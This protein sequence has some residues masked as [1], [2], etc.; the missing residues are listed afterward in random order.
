MYFSLHLR[1][2]GAAVV[3][4]LT[5]SHA[6]VS[7]APSQCEQVLSRFGDKLIDAA[8]ADSADLTTANLA[9]TPANNAIATLPPFAFTPQA[10]RDT[11]APDP[12]HRTPIAGPVPGVQINARI[13]ED[14]QGQAR[15]LI[16]LPDN[17]NGRLVVAGAP[18]TRSEFNG[19]FA[20]SDY[21]VQKGY[22]YVAQNKGTLNLRATTAADPT[23]CRLNPALGKDTFVHFYDDDPGMP[24]TRW[25]PLMAEA[26]RLGRAA[27][28]IHYGRD[29]QY[30]YAV[31]TSNGGYQVRRA[32]ESYPEL[33][34][35]GVDWEGTFVDADMPNLLSTL[36]P[37]ILNYPAH[38]ASGFDPDSKAAKN[39]RAAGYP[40]DLITTQGDPPTSLWRVHYLQFW[41]VTMCQWQ[42][43]L[44]P[45]YDTYGAGL[46]N[47]VYVNRLS[48]SNVGE[49]LADF[50]TTGRIRR[51]LITVAGTMDALLPIDANARAY[52]RRVAAV[53]REEARKASPAYRLYEVQNGNHIETF[54]VTFPQLEFIQP[55]ALQ[56]FDL[57][58][59]AIENQAELPPSQCIPRGGK[60]AK[61][62]AQPGHCTN[63]MVP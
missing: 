28:Q 60:I 51:P 41:E 27:V 13:A 7:A 55:H 48:L 26:A 57:L 6:L 53:A 56:A 37:A 45:A 32:V 54:K 36:P 43:R 15:V 40:P 21:V 19:D 39:I 8:C 44:D 47:Y 10:D 2:V 52:A 20:W 1:W 12:P 59:S 22:A 29:A 3:A 23:A 24:F 5:I 35:G 17:W 49:S 9:T 46:G 50:R 30:T 11:I 58:V 33:F 61:N 4:A 18:G 14:P 42:K 62:P 16:R 63:L 25:A 38:A 31:G 34:D